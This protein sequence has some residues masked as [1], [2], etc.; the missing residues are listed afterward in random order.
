MRECVRSV[1]VCVFSARACSVCNVR[2]ERYLGNDLFVATRPALPGMRHTAAGYKHHMN[3]ST[4]FIHHRLKENKVHHC[5]TEE[6]KAQRDIKAS[7]RE[8]NSERVRE[9]DR[10]SVRSAEERWRDG[11]PEEPRYSVEGFGV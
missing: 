6:R 8:I 7:E 10:G 3:T 4:V 5:I 1:C 9:Q 11:T 2:G